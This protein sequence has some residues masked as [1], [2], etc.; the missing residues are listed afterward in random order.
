[1][2]YYMTHSVMPTSDAI[3]NIISMFGSTFVL[4]IEL[5]PNINIV[6]AAP[7]QIS[8]LQE[9]A[10]HLFLDGTFELCEGKL[11]LTTLM[12]KVYE[13]GVPVGW[14]LSTSKEA[15]NYADWLSYPK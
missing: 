5:H 12:V 8:L 3:S 4:K 11:I 13:I 7:G 14:L 15:E 2:K 10:R 9:Y 1:M 6:L